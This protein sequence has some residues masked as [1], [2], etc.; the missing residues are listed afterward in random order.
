MSFFLRIFF[1][2]IAVIVVA[3]A[4]PA[5]Y[6]SQ[7]LQKNMILDI[8]EQ[9]FDK[10]E[11]MTLFFH[12][13]EE[14]T[15]PKIAYNEINAQL[16][17]LHL[18]LTL[19]DEHGEVL[20]DSQVPENSLDDLD[21]H[22][23]RIEIKGAMTEG[24][25]VSSRFSN[26]LNTN[27]IY[28]A[29][30]L[31]N[32]DLLRIAY[33][34]KNVE[35]RIANVQRTMMYVFIASLLFAFAIAFMLSFGIKKQ[36]KTMIDVVDA[37]SLGK[38]GSRLRYVPG[39]EFAVLASAV[40]RM[41]ENIEDHLD[42]MQEQSMQLKVIF[43]TMQD[44]ILLLDSKGNIR[45][46][47]K[48]LREIA[49]YISHT[50][51]NIHDVNE[52]SH[53][54]TFDADIMPDNINMQ[55]IECINSP[56]LQNAIEMILKSDGNELATEHMDNTGSNNISKTVNSYT[57]PTGNA[58]GN[59]TGTSIGVQTQSLITQTGAL[60]YYIE[61]ELFAG[62][63]FA[64]SLAKPENPSQ[65]MGLVLVIHEITEI[66]RLENVRRD[67]VANVSHELRTPLTSIQGYA[68]TLAT[69]PEL[70]DACKRFAQ[71]IYK[72]GNYLN[73]MI[74]DLLALARIENTQEVCLLEAID[75]N[76]ALEIALDF[77][78]KAMQKQNIGLENTL[79]ENINDIKV[80][81]NKAHLER[82]FRNLLENACRY[83]VPHSVIKV[84][85]KEEENM[86]MFTVQNK[87]ARI[88]QEDIERIFER[89]YRVEKGRQTYTSTNTTD[90]NL[91]A[92][93]NNSTNGT[94]TGL[95]L[96]ICKH[97]IER[98]GGRIWA[99]SVELEEEG[100]SLA[101]TSFH[102]TLKIC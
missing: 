53:E 102:F 69:M 97:I 94:A 9:A 13:D 45:Q 92:D 27:F 10:L 41:A 58:T 76:E 37:I 77:C 51:K 96:A 64:I 31:K 12:I 14:Y 89:F 90:N 38:L 49:P 79:P 19:I 35:K 43:N 78:D 65:A 93:T 8:E 22:A 48:A 75:P 95:G 67:F 30:R 34:H 26:T 44:G 55:I 47:N 18:R 2:L 91:N 71:I 25:G 62:R 21:N 23:D 101:L 83:A 1:S 39:Q 54:G 66:V 60:S 98:H 28:V 59:V 6:F 42:I 81:A 86:C 100:T 74:D 4:V 5:Y 46:S 3:T 16:E 57:A 7:N 50:L 32:G 80:Q 63:F 52:H 85:A 61:L 20:F 70:S 68:E 17:A 99:Q 40:N 82:V 84:F 88:P 29:T 87:G 24:K 33:P 11:L 56:I 73:T 36:L 15:T 72:H